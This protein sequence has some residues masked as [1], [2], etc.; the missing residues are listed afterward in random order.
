M[1]RPK[2][3]A[4]YIKKTFRRAPLP[5]KFPRAAVEAVRKI[6]DEAQNS[7]AD[8]HFRIKYDGATGKTKIE[9]VEY[10]LVWSG[11]LKTEEQAPA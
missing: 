3:E 4:L 5:S 9:R 1:K 11:Y 2:T 8:I 6:E 10:S 7:K